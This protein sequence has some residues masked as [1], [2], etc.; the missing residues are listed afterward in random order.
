MIRDLSAGAGPVPD[1]DPVPDHDPAATMVKVEAEA[2]L[3]L[4]HTADHN[5][6]PHHVDAA[7]ARAGEMIRI[8]MT[9]NNMWH[10]N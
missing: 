2:S 9:T 6:I 5:Q 8:R 4:G 3:A 7:Q 1:P 10:M